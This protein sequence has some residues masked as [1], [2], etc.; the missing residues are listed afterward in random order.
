MKNFLTTL[1]NQPVGCNC[2]LHIA[3]TN[4]HNNRDTYLQKDVANDS[5]T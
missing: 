2:F 1:K 5:T 4:T 3:T